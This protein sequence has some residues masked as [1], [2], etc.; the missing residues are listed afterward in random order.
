[1][2]TYN[3]Q[4]SLY[5][6]VHHVWCLIQNWADCWLDSGQ[7]FIGIITVSPEIRT[8]RKMKCLNKT[9]TESDQFDLDVER[10][11]LL[12]GRYRT[13]TVPIIYP[14]LICDRIICSFFSF[15][16]AAGGWLTR[17]D[18]HI[19]FSPL[20]LDSLTAYIVC[21]VIK[22]NVPAYCTCYYE[23]VSYK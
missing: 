22:K 6:L 2:H 17:T 9:N 11:S 15:H 8:S 4:N 7:N 12:Y 5:K 20:K 23:I 1:M 16:L 18:S 13:N 21:S 19:H 3:L 10:T 14:H